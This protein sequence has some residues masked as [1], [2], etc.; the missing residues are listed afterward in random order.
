[1]S[2]SIAEPV[3]PAAHPPRLLRLTAALALV[4]LP[5]CFTFTHTVGNGPANAKA[6]VV[7]AEETRWFALYGIVPFND[8]DSKSLAGGARDYRVTTKFTVLD[9]VI[10]CFTSFVTIYRQT[11]IVEK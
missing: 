8:A 5:G 6:P 2:N 10:T 4:L 3:R 11:V 7:A 9:C 1:M